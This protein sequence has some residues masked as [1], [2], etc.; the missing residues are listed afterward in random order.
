RLDATKMT[1]GL[2]IALRQRPAFG[3]RLDLDRFNLNA[4]L[5]GGGE[6]GKG[7]AA[8]GLKTESQAG[9]DTG[10]RKPTSLKGSGK[11]LPGALAA[12]GGFDANFKITAGILDYNKMAIKGARLDGTIQGGKL[13]LR[14]AGASDLAGARI[15]VVGSLE[16]LGSAPQANLGFDLKTKNL[17]ALFRL[18]G[19]EPPEYA[20]RMGALAF[21]GKLTGPLSSLRLDAGLDVA[22]T[23]A[24]LAGVVEDMILVPRI[25]MIMD[26]THSSVI[27]L[28][29]VFAPDY[30]PAAVKLGG[31]SFRG[32]IHGDADRLILSN[33]D[34]KVGPVALAGEAQFA[35]GGA[36]PHVT[37]ILSGSEIVTDLFLPAAAKSL[38]LRREWRIRPIPAATKRKQA[39]PAPSVP[40]SKAPIDLS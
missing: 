34:S 17:P 14:D 10:E 32:Q 2:T 36:R 6:A 26:V 7:M 38:G 1:G 37:A 24:T 19:T 33:I 28:A 16:N 9:G 22:G 25:N 4:Y 29:Q 15:K 20:S 40:W 12:L 30:R 27:K 35:F 31:F 23:K 11:K 21:T 8:K 5:P 3:L 39:A 18:G 13:T